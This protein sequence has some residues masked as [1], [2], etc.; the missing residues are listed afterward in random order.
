MWIKKR[1]EEKDTHLYIGA[2]LSDHLKGEYNFAPK[3]PR[4]CDSCP[5][6]YLPISCPCIFLQ[7]SPLYSLSVSPSR[8]ECF[9]HCGIPNAWDIASTQYVFV[10]WMYDSSVT[11][12]PLPSAPPAP[13]HFI[14]LNVSHQWISCWTKAVSRQEG[15]SY[16]TRNQS[17]ALGHPQILKRC[18]YSH[19][20]SQ[21]LMN[22]SQMQ[23]NPSLQLSRDLGEGRK[24]CSG[25][26]R[27]GREW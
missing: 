20:F 8:K 6:F 26:G 23:R 16:F 9:V 2:P 25:K 10:E 19:R 5:T 4:N 21:M 3:W 15:R 14:H 27:G 22:S 13:Q 18:C 1:M 7:F 17:Q 11:M 12:I 24:D